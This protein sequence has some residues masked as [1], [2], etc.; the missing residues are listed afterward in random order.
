MEDGVVAFLFVDQV[1][2]TAQLRDLGDEG[3]APVRAAMFDIIRRAL[4]EH[5]GREVDHTGDGMMATFSRPSDAMRASAAI[6]L[7]AR[8]HNRAHP[9]GQHLG[10]RAGLHAGDPLIDDD[11]RHFGMAIVIA[12]R[13]CAQADEA[14]ILVSDTLRGLVVGRGEFHF[15]P[16]GS[17]DL[18]GVGEAVVTHALR[19][20]DS[21]PPSG[22]A[23]RPASADNATRR[24]LHPV[25][26]PL[27]LDQLIGRESER[28]A[29]AEAIE[30]HRLV[31]VIGVGGI[32]KT[33]LAVAAAQDRAATFD[34]GAC[35]VDLASIERPGL[36]VTTVARGTG[37]FDATAEAAGREQ[38][39]DHVVTAMRGR[40]Q[41]LVIDNCE[42]VIDE[43]ARVVQRLLAEG[44][45]LKVL[46]T[47]R[48][49]L[50]L[51]GERR[52]LLG[53]LGSDAVPLFLARAEQ[54][55]VTLTA[56]DH[57]AVEAIC[58]RL[59][60]IPLAVELVAARTASL[61]L[62]DLELRLEEALHE[63]APSLRGMPKRHRTMT[64][65]LDWSHGLLDEG[66]KRTFRRLSVFSGG[67]TVTGAE[68]VAAEP[69][70]GATS[71]LRAHLSTLVE[72]SLVGFDGE[73]YRFL[74]PVRQYAAAR[75]VAA[76][77]EEATLAAH[78]AYVLRL[79]RRRGR[80]IVS[81]D[82][83][84]ELPNY[85]VAIQR[86]LG[87]GDA[88]G[89]LTL[90]TSLGWFWSS[91]EITGELLEL[92]EAA[93]GLGADLPTDLCFHSHALLA[94]GYGLDGRKADAHRHVDA[95]TAL[96][97]GRLGWQGTGISLAVAIEM[98]GD[99]PVGVLEAAEDE[100][101]AHDAPAAAALPAVLASWWLTWEDRLD[102]ALR[103]ATRSI[104]YGGIHTWASWQRAYLVVALGG[105][106]DRSE[107]E[108]L[109]RLSP[110]GTGYDGVVGPLAL[111]A[112]GETRRALAWSESA[113]SYTGVDGR[114]GYHEITMRVG[115]ILRA[116]V[117]D[118][119]NA[120]ILL[121]AADATRERFGFPA[122]AHLDRL[123]AEDVAPALATLTPVERDAALRLGAATPRSELA[124]L[125]AG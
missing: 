120:A 42:H 81:A 24:A 88:V 54:V 17:L 15:E 114:V 82:D 63:P 33:R 20:Q 93:L 50:G 26:L 65:T 89:A 57:A 45:R 67:W 35:F 55:G 11:G 91:N 44:P 9:P 72:R 32:G 87:C 85:R 90:I 2:S 104:D 78:H 123:V 62:A 110:S 101:L 84:P 14:Q 39:E 37:A 10:L 5:A 113:L 13:L 76:G 22:V 60:G 79:A 23:T 116:R 48:E 73:R 59:D 68:A 124:G 38:L 28:T 56:D 106:V 119:E 69:A 58:R 31:S 71:D 98:L 118:E 30:R 94:S 1:G 49:P 103:A 108:D 4:T 125:I 66:T 77:D 96:D 112:L 86:A 47:S 99:S 8:A 111:Q 43:A 16:I 27:P 100:A 95:A 97:D 36:V 51:P 53:S 75:L 40:E 25:T 102:E 64:S 121:G 74:E 83:G 117:G 52:I 109:L 107:L 70:Q 92:G 61:P 41:L 7:G 105:T 18:K 115:A 29:L 80:V 46:A 6:Q 12:A 122:R 3:A 19:W 34:D 21:P